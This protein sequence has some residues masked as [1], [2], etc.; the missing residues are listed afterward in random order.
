[1]TTLSENQQD[2]ALWRYGIISPLLHREANDRLMHEILEELARNKYRHPSGN[3]MDISPET[4]R[5]WLYR[6]TRN[7]LPGLC[8]KERSD[9]GQYQIPVDLADALFALRQEHP[10]WTLARMLRAVS[11]KGQWNGVRPSRSSIYRFAAASNLQRDPHL[12]TTTER[13]SFAFDLFGQLWVADFLHGPKL[14]VG[15]QK[16]KTYL[17][18][19]LDDCSRFVVRGGFYLSETVEPLICDLMEA[20]KRFGLPQRFYTDNGAAYASR[21]LKL[22]CGRCGIHLVHTPPYVPQGRGKVER[23]FRTIRDQFLSGTIF[24][25]LDDINREFAGWVARYHEGIHSSLGCSPLQKRLEAGSVCRPIPPAADTEALFRME[26]RSRV[27]ANGTVRHKNTLYE[28]PGCPSGSRVTLYYMP[29]ESGVVYYGD[30][31]RRAHPLDLQ[32]NARRFDKPARRARRSE[33]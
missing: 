19:I 24:K 31:M 26:K 15:K 10:R 21:H 9:K 33:S 13:Q 6:Y 7:G 22:V 23:I 25:S 27:Y 32:K 11:E 12:E 29:W 4:L 8:D 5:K 17:H 16:K 14:W 20:S 28:V 2:I 1:M 30:D 3:D 18:L